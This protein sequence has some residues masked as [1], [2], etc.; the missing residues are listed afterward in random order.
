MFNWSNIIGYI[1][2]QNSYDGTMVLVSVFMLHLFISINRFAEWKEK[3]LYVNKTHRFSYGKKKAR[4]ALSSLRFFTLF[5][6]LFSFNKESYNYYKWIITYCRCS[7]T[8]PFKVSSS[9]ENSEWKRRQVLCSPRHLTATSSLLYLASFG[10]NLM[11]FRV[12]VCSKLNTNVQL[13]FIN[14]RKLGRRK[15][16]QR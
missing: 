5:I 13:S 1:S 2:Y 3:S 6:V 16:S 4:W 8:R 9:L 15:L 11:W 7:F 12:K 14:K 10:M